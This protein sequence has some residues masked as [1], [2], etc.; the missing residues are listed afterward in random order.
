MV[1][2]WYMK[3]LIIALLL[4]LPSISHAEYIYYYMS[5]DET[6]EDVA[7]KF[8]VDVS[9]IQESEI[10]SGLNWTQVVINTTPVPKTKPIFEDGTIRKEETKKVEVAE[11]K[12]IEEVKAKIAQLQQLIQLLIQLME[13][14]HEQ[15]I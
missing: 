15:N 9:Q 6:Y 10:A 12:D 8:N 7:K 11:D 13:L 1:A 2:N 3:I 4:V 14:K 5:N